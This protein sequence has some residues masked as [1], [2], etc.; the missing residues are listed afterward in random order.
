M[1]TRSHC[2]DLFVH[3]PSHWETM[4]HC[5]V[6]SH[7]LS[8]YTKRTLH[9]LGATLWY[10]GPVYWLVIYALVNSL[11]PE[12]CGRNFKKNIFFKLICW[13]D[14]LNLFY[15]IGLR[16]VPHNPID[17]NSTLVQVMVMAWCRQAT[18]HYLSQC[19]PKSM[20]PCGVTRPQWVNSSIFGSDNGL[21]PVWCQA[22]IQTNAGLLSIKC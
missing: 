22:I 8:A 12:R 6:G 18:S 5:N 1:V 10:H 2:R 17:D 21:L 9:W 4:L 20:S 7:W 13:I 15:E 3:T 19:W 14:I 16:W 11:V